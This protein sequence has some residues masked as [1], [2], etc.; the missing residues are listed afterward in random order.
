MS[1]RLE[2]GAA[3]RNVTIRRAVTGVDV[4]RV[5]LPMAMP[6]AVHHKVI[7]TPCTGLVKFVCFTVYR[8]FF[9][10]GNFGENATWKVC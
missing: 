4:S 1:V 9:A 8:E 10:S 5:I 2:T 7:N 6:Q 3:A